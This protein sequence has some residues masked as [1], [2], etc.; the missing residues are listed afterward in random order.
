MGIDGSE[1]KTV[2][3]LLLNRILS[4]YEAMRG[5]PMADGSRCAAMGYCFGGMAVLDRE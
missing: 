3:P 2:T 1:Y 4:G 5:M